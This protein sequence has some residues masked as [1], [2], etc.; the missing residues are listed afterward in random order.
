MI[1]GR[2]GAAAA[3]MMILVCAHAASG[4]DLMPVPGFDGKIITVGEL[5]PLTGP[6]ANFGFAVA[7]GVKAWLHYLNQE[8]GGVAGRYK[9][10]T[11]VEDNALDQAMTVQSYNKIKTQVAMI[12]MLFGTHTTLAVLPQIKEDKLLVSVEGADEQ[13]FREENLL[14]VG[15]TYQVIAINA[16]DYLVHERGA[17]NKVFCGLIRDDPYGAAGLAGLK[18]ATEKLHLNLALVAHFTISD[19]DFS[20]QVAQLK[21]ANCDYIYA[22]TI[23]PQLVRLVGNVVRV[24]FAPTI[25]AQFPSWTGTLVNSPAIDFFEQHLLVAAEGSEWGDDQSPQMV[26]MIANLKKYTPDQKPDFF[27]LMGYRCAMASTAVLEKAAAS[28]DISRPALLA[29]L[30][31]IKTMDFGGLAGEH[32]YGPANQREAP[33]TSSVFKVKH[34]KPYGLEALKVNFASP[35]VALYEGH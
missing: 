29:A 15:A 30:D 34:I 10:E 4:A 14:P 23:P 33:R 32:H 28:G 3:A 5:Q 9:V 31:S 2:I 16:V 12:A 35:T 22:T 27:F 7:N 20:G 24:G 26:Q 8:K 18:F 1:A 17:Q 21:D 11:L 6:A 13:F 19:Q 25:V